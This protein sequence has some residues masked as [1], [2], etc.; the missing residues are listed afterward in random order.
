VQLPGGGAAQLAVV[1][2]LVS[3]F[4]VAPDVAVSCGILLWL[5]T[6]MA[7]VPAGLALLRGYGL[8]LRKLSTESRR[9]QSGSA[10]VSP[11]QPAS[12]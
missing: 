7:P 12:S 1:A 3:V 11:S 8:S 2:A 5:A 4:S 6:Y 9:Q 10:A